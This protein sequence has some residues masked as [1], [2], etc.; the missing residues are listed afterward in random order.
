MRYSAKRISSCHRNDGEKDISD[1]ALCVV[2]GVSFALLLLPVPIIETPPGIDQQ[3]HMN[4]EPSSS[5]VRSSLEIAHRLHTVGSY[6]YR[7]KDVRQFGLEIHRLSSVPVE[8]GFQDALH[9]LGPKCSFFFIVLPPVNC[10]GLAALSNFR[11]NNCR[12]KR[13]KCR[14]YRKM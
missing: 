6:E 9:I 10:N 1:D 14:V 11:G 8:V 12:F 2:F 13:H 5:T 3:I 4:S 7:R